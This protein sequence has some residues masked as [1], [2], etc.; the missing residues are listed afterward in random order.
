VGRPD[1]AQHV[2]AEMTKEKLAHHLYHSLKNKILPLSDD[3]II[4]PGHGAGSACGKNLSKETSDTLGNQKET[5]AALRPG[6]SEEQ[7]IKELLSG[8]MPPPGYFPKN[9]LMNIGGY[10]SIKDVLKQGLTPLSPEE[11]K[12][13]AEEKNAV[14]LDTR[15]AKLFGDGF[16]PGAV[17]IGLEGN[18]APWVGAVLPDINQ[19]IVFISE[20]GKEEDVVVRL[21][22]VGYDHAIGFL[23]G[24]M[25]AWK[26]SGMPVDTVPSIDSVKLAELREANPEIQIVDIRKKSEYDSE[27]IVGVNNAPLDYIG[28]SKSVVP[29]DGPVYIHCAG[30]YRSMIFI[31]L[32]KQKGFQNLVNVSD[33][34]SGIK[35]SGR[36]QLTEYVCPTTML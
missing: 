6:L 17:N 12:S 34:F 19:P 13:K 35:N 8:L 4:Y 25:D 1:L 28:E 30:G 10:E 18:F 16:I 26:M 15:S 21:A 22:R 29:Q 7:F 3:I 27:H 9:V 31:S 20:P 36:F 32:L 11:F 23:K 2:I 5:N 24:G 14:I 33:G